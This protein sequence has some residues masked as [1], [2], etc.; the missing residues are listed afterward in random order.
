M[1]HV[2]V[3]GGGIAGL[4]AALAVRRSAPGAEVTVLEA[5]AEVGGKL[6]VSEV[7]GVPVDEGAEAL[8]ARRPEAAELARAVG[9][10]A[11]LITP[12]T[13]AASV[14]ARG[15]LRPLPSGTVFGVPRSLAALGGVL[16]PAER[17]RA[18]LDRVLPRTPVGDDVAVGPF[19][20]ARL[21]RPV[22]DRL[23]DPLLGGVY[24]GRADDLSLAA[25]IPALAR[26]AR[27][28]RSLLRAS[29]AAA[30]APAPGPVFWALRG[31][32]GRLPAA[33]AAYA[34]ARVRTRCPVRGL[35]RT[36]TGWRLTVGSAADPGCVDA[37][38]VVLA[39][40]AA[41]A[42]RLLAGL[43]PAAAADLAG[44]GYASVA[45]VTL[46][47]REPVPIPG[48]G[49][50]VPASAGRLVKGVTLTTQKWALPGP[51]IVRCSIGRAGD[52]ADLQREDADLVAAARA[53]LAALTGLAAEPVASR[54]TRWGGGLPQYGVGHL[55]RVA[56]IRAAVALQPR[57]AACG[58]AYAG[59][60]VPACIADGTRAGNA[61]ATALSAPL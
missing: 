31:G 5:T 41:A 3:V 38:G 12:A 36:A 16:D 55:D 48:S 50:L 54:V 19:V 22:V 60:G 34:G 51:G 32:V 57:L 39:V 13:L 14:Y 49:F 45:I 52:P 28:E 1:P 10:G 53:D 23:V 6:R 9:L 7:A 59:I 56:R 20:A 11:D 18:A 21:G 35:E 44:I 2:V 27:R 24:A 37:D 15:R 46:G 40:P 47:Y 30:P 61:V 17:A 33:V 42:A 8:L 58:A 25:T 4:A 43:A 26:A 29:A